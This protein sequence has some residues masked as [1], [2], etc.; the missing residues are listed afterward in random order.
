MEIEV[1]LGGTELKLAE[2]ESINLA[3]ANEVAELKAA[4]EG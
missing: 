4:L 2:V 3:H 1:K